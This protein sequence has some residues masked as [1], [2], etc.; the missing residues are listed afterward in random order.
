M[1][2]DIN[3]LLTILGMSNPNISN[4]SN[5][6]MPTQKN[7]TNMSAVEKLKNLPSLLESKGIDPL[8]T[9]MTLLNAGG[10]SDQKQTP[11]QPIT[12]ALAG[13]RQAFQQNQQMQQQNLLN[14]LRLGTT[15]NQLNQTNTDNKIRTIFQNPKLT[16]QEKI[17]L[18]KADNK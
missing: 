5:I 8:M 3:K 11:L 18:I 6:N 16:M 17:S 12:T 7:F 14:N 2:P 9:G 4:F 15:L 1:N 13:G 10:Y